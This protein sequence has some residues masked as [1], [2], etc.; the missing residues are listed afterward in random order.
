MHHLWHTWDK[1]VLVRE[2]PYFEPYELVHP[3][4]VYKIFERSCQLCGDVQS[5]R[6]Q[7]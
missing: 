4:K 7:S 1:W 2:Y 5:K 6:V 3:S